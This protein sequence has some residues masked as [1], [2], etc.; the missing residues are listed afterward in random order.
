MSN[1]WFY[2][3]VVAFTNIIIV[4]NLSEAARRVGL[5][6]HTQGNLTPTEMNLRIIRH[7]FQV[8]VRRPNDEPH[9][10]LIGTPWRALTTTKGLLGMKDPKRTWRTSEFLVLGS[11]SAKWS[12]CEAQQA[13]ANE[14]VVSGVGVDTAE[15]VRPS[16]KRPLRVHPV[17]D[18]VGT[19]FRGHPFRCSTRSSTQWRR[20]RIAREQRRWHSS[21]N[22]WLHRWMCI[23]GG[24]HTASLAAQKLSKKS[25]VCVYWWCIDFGEVVLFI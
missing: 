13:L 7:G 9:F 6:R 4:M 16:E 15:I 20:G 12:Y 18:E 25:N 3:L 1:R 17:R 22:S 5:N 2:L 19:K 10:F 23:F 8:E 11:N 21:M 14:S 24:H